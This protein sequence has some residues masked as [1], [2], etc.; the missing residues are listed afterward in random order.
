MSYSE[1][2]DLTPINNIENGD[3]YIKA[4]NWAFQ[5]SKIKN[6][7]L[8]GPYGAGKSSV[9]ETFLS[10]DDKK[11]AQEGW[12]SLKKS[13][14][15]SALKIS[16]ATFIKGKS[17]ENNDIGQKIDVSADEVEKGILK[18]LFYKVEPYRIPQSRYRKLHK[19]SF[20]SIFLH[21]AV[22][23][24]L[25]GLLLA[26][27]APLTYEKFVESIKTFVPSGIYTTIIIALLLVVLSAVGAYLYLTVISKFKVKEIKLPTDTTVQSGDEDSDSV[28]N[29]NLDEIM[30]FFESTGYRIVFFEDL[31]RL[32]D[33]KIFVHLRE[34]NNLLNND[35]AIKEKPI[36]FVYAVRDDI[37]SKEDRT[38]FFDFI[39]PIIPVINST[40]SGEILLKMLQESNENGI[41]HNISQGFVLDI[42]PYISDMRLLQNIYNE[43][44]VY[45]KTLCISQNLALPD[46]QMMAIIVFKNL[47]PS[48]FADIQDEKGILKK[49][50]KDKD[51]FIARKRKSLQEEIDNSSSVITRAHNDTLKSVRELKYAMI[52][53]LMGGFHTFKGFGN[54]WSVQI[55]ASNFLS[56]NFDVNQ[57]EQKDCR[58]I[59]ANVY[60]HGERIINIDVDVLKSYIERWKAIEDLEKTGLRK[61]QRNIQ[62]LHNKQHALSGMTFVRIF[63][64]YSTGEVLS[65][66]VRKNKLLTFLLRRGYI[67]EKY[68]NYINYFKG[69]SITKDDMNFILSVKNQTPLP[70]DYSLTKISMV[71]DQ[72][73]EYEFEQ[74]AIY[75]FDLLDELLKKEQSEKLTA[76]ITQLSDESEVSWK[77]IDEFMSN[78][79]HQDCFVRLLVERWPGMW[80]HISTDKTLTYERQLMY[81]KNILN[82]S[83]VN[84]IKIQNRDESLTYYFEQHDDILQKLEHCS[85]ANITSVIRLLNVCFKELK[86]ND[87][88]HEILDFVFDNCCYMLNSAMIHTIVVYKNCSMVQQ[89][90]SSPYT[91]VIA[92]K[93]DALIKYIHE[94]FITYV[95]DIVLTHTAL[96]DS[97]EDIVDMLIRLKNEKELQLQLIWQENFHLNS[98]E[99]CAGELVQTESHL[100]QHVWDALLE[101]N[102][103]STNWSNV[104]SYWKVYHFSDELKKYITIHVDELS[105]VDTVVDDGFIQM[106]I[107]EKLE[108]EIKKKLIPVLRM[109]A[110]TL[111]IT[112]ID[113][114]VLEI[115]IDCKYFEFTVDHYLN[116][117]SVS[118]NMGLEFILKNQSAYMELRKSISMTTDLFESLML[119]SKLCQEYKVT[120]FS[121]YAKR[122]MTK[123]V[124]YKMNAMHWPITKDVFEAAWECVDHVH[125]EK[126]LLENCE[127]L[128]ANNLEQRFREIGGIYGE[129]ADR[130]RR[131]EVTLSAVP[132][133][134]LLV[135]HLEKIGYITS[136]EEKNEKKF[137]PVA[138]KEIVR[139]IL[140]MRIKQTK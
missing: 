129:L 137:N 131:H 62:E 18:Q 128:D 134:M 40:N 47:Y 133:N 35:D 76:F 46:Q 20:F 41:R 13:I 111:D 130:T 45:K 100:W 42:A 90:E 2:R 29:R 84:N 16:M 9:I 25:I 99:T 139:K 120:L 80:R 77:F 64:L 136:W 104:I 5:N 93:Y 135:Q 56:D 54:G 112:S 109:S 81:L 70:F 94:N 110:F 39:I 117:S 122:Y 1:Y 63:S 22:A 125:Q 118:T 43:F 138:E 85:V 21:I 74:K 140:K 58:N 106:F 71:I 69:T 61:L 91:T 27:F 89:L 102:A 86:I 53:T 51:E 48:D 30:Y 6:I 12:F 101:K 127:L 32:S 105:V 65:D 96:S 17:A 14:R 83:S 10:Q 87:V 73:Q 67:D 97:P 49:A 126:L 23:L 108:L 59:V 19:I 15:Q 79:V 3:E 124:A 92:L 26:I 31:D 132:E 95:R 37:F 78:T 33:P 52:V 123:N 119:S 88:K 34:L 114:T 57:L 11:V 28:F 66:E 7:A 72:L 44:V 68:A 115:M 4:L 113:E 75:N 60:N 38:K 55:P 50:F 116:V 82:L 36:V 8:T 121:E 103:I 107:M 98:I 24:F